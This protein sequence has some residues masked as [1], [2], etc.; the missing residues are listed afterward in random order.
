MSSAQSATVRTRPA[1][2]STLLASPIFGPA[3]AL[4]LVSVFFA[5]TAPRFLSPGTFSLILQQVMVV[6]VMAIG[7]TLIIVTTGIDLSCGMLM[8]LSGLLMAGFAVRG[9]LNPWLAMLLGIGVAVLFGFLNGA[10]VT[11][12][13]LP[14]FIVTL[15]TMNIAW[16]L[17]RIY[18][19]STITLTDEQ[20]PLLFLGT[21]IKVGGTELPPPGILLLLILYVVAWFMMKYTAAGRSVYAVGDNIEAARLAGI[22]TKRVLLAVYTVAGM[23]YGI[24]A[25]LQIARTGVGD[26]NAGESSNGNMD[27][28]TAAVI[29]GTSLFGGRGSMAGTL[30]GVMIVGILR[31]GLQLM[32][33]PT[34]YQVLVTG[35]LVIAAVSVDQLTHRK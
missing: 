1:F 3:A 27:A 14:A 22:N 25:L 28:I 13:G 4:V 33:I 29:G 8:G 24:A 18:S 6:G 2:V 5:I 31:A 9:G 10:L 12:V 21:P 23:A 32:G 15:G 17:K 30:I 19:T 20:A 34:T 11:G 16:A 35:V 7:Q 26:P